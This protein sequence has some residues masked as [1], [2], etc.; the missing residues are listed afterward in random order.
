MA[1][2]LCAWLS[3]ANVCFPCCYHHSSVCCNRSHT[4]AAAVVVD[5]RYPGPHAEAQRL[6]PL[7]QLTERQLRLLPP[8]SLAQLLCATTQLG[9][10][11]YEEWRAAAADAAAA[12]FATAPL[13]ELLALLHGAAAAGCS[14]DASWWGLWFDA[15]ASRAAAISLADAAAAAVTTTASTS[16]GSDSTTAHNDSSWPST[17]DAQQQQQQHLVD[18][19]ALYSSGGGWINDWD[20]SSSGDEGS[21]VSV[22]QVLQAE[23]LMGMCTLLQALGVSPTHPLWLAGMLQA[24][25]CSAYSAAAT[26]LLLQAVAALLEAPE[27]FGERHAA[28]L[29]ALLQPL[30]E[31]LAELSADGLTAAA[32]AC[33]VFGTRPGVE[34]WRWHAAA[35]LRLGR[36][37]PLALLARLR[38]AYAVLGVAPEQRAR[39][40]LDS[41]PW[42][43]ARARA[44]ER[45]AVSA[46]AR[47]ATLTAKNEQRRRQNEAD[48]ASR[49]ARG[50]GR[51]GW[52]RRKLRLPGTLDR[53]F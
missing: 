39:Q 32:E 42:R 9:Q 49:A 2:Q 37:Y 34:W 43:L 50:E 48:A 7:L 10:A 12:H 19:S 22:P 33:V 8:G 27:E 5:G 23:E 52:R 14:L 31:R 13:A 29:Q 25:R 21:S 17:L 40:L 18:S 53:R 20:T 16:I 28:L 24:Y 30:R 1:R 11:S 51:A 3:L 45:A 46:A 26:P 6:Q 41:V 15:C 38:D 35:A 36:T 44:K 4:A 47:R